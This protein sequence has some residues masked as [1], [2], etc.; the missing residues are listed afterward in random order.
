MINLLEKHRIISLIFT[1]LVA[2]EI[3]FF[4]GKVFA[5]GKKGLALLPI[6]YHFVIFFLLSFFLLMTIKGN[7]RIELKYILLTLFISLAYAISDEIHQYFVPGRDASIDDILI[8][9]S[10]II[11]SMMVYIYSKRNVK[12]VK[13]N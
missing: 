4:S 5:P 8:D 9:T 12:K 1:L 10:G 3:F 7:R 13:N 11:T 2:V 6:I